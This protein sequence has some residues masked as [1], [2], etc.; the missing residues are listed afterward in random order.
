M[1]SAPVPSLKNNAME[2]R[3]NKTK[4]QIV[5]GV[6]EVGRGPLAGP[7]MAC[8]VAALNLKSQILNLKST[9][10]KLNFVR[11]SKKLS[12]KQ[13]E[14]IFDMVKK[15]PKIKW[16]LGRVGEGVIDKINIFEATKRA[17]VR[18]V[19]VLEKKLGKKANM[20]LIDGNFNI[21][22]KRNQQSIIKGD[23]KIPLIALASIIA[24]VSRDNLMQ[25]QSKK[26]PQYGFA[27][28]KGYGTRHHIDMLNKIGPCK[29]HRASFAP[30][31]EAHK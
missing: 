17:M 26:Y 11:D 31:K 6:D 30:I 3:Q 2:K 12:P 25:K 22:I 10:K 24:K 27:K 28:N 5:F 29:I 16:A 19:L 18:A 20:L 4:K 23:E 21:P 15:D 14:K 7:V 1:G 8:A 9:S 13:R